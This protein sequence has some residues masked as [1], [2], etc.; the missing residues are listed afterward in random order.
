MSIVL[1]AT[2]YPEKEHRDDV[3]AA[4]ET[5]VPLVHDEAGCE[6][7]AMFKGADRIVMIEKWASAED[8]GAH[9]EGEAL[10][11]L[12][13][14]LDGK[15]AQKLDVQFLEAHPAGTESQGTLS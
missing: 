4:I 6:L 13:A 2:F 5:S 1:V 11:S 14:Q 7:Y 15:L 9:G 3:V 12:M 8:L 10:T